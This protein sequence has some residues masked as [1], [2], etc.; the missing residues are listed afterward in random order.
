[1]NPS[2]ALATS[3]VYREVNFISTV[4]FFSPFFLVG[5]LEVFV[6]PWATSGT[7]REPSDPAIHRRSSG[8]GA[9]GPWGESMGFLL[10]S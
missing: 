9:F 7:S 2:M 3:E 10:G 8:Q 6:L 4:H 5:I 1:M